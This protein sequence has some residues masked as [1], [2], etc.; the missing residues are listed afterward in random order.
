MIVMVALLGVLLLLLDTAAA[1]HAVPG[2]CKLYNC[3]YEFEPLHSCQCYSGCVQY[4]TCCSDY[5]T[6][7][8]CMRHHWAASRSHTARN[9]ARGHALLRGGRL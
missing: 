1:Q 4:D 5:K 9:S 8:A 6:V 3:S 2:S 7:R